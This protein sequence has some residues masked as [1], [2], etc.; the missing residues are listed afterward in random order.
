MGAFAVLALL[1]ALVL[2][3]AVESGSDF[4]DASA[5]ADSIADENGDTDND[6]IDDDPDAE[7]EQTPTIQVSGGETATGTD[8]AEVF[9]L[10]RGVEGAATIDAQG[11][12]DI[13]MASDEPA[14]L[15]DLLPSDFIQPV[16]NAGMGDDSV[17][18]DVSS[19]AEINA[20]DGDDTVN[21]ITA[22]SASVDGGLGN[23]SI[24]VE[25]EGFD[26]STAS[27]GEGDDTITAIGAGNRV[28]GDAGDDVIK[29]SGTQGGG[30]GLTSAADGGLGNDTITTELDTRNSFDD[31]LF[32]RAMRVSGGEGAD[33]F[34]AQV[35]NEDIDLESVQRFAD[36]SGQTAADVLAEP[37]TLLVID[38]FTV[39]E[40]VLMIEDITDTEGML[41]DV[42]VTNGTT[43]SVITLTF[44][45]PNQPSAISQIIVNDTT[46]SLDDI[47][48]VGEDV[49]MAASA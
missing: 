42:V 45:N 34:V 21:L 22:A 19:N 18:I 43:N 32:G 36:L 46:L 31:F 30:D 28:F 7:P 26:A 29:L 39:G 37:G 23:D 33:T 16:I 40:D 12:N 35:R 27:G 47:L 14:D 10:T 38:D 1:S 49:P 17:N 20:G 13:F 3:P 9:E 11:G 44:E 2:V 25:S 6:I 24:S 8:D 41:A 15:N 4:D 5:E 48:V